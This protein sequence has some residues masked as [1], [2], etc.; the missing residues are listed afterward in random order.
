M[1]EK[2]AKPTLEVTACELLGRGE[3][4]DI[5][6]D[7]DSFLKENNL[8]ASTTSVSYK[9][10]V[11]IYKGKRICRLKLMKENYWIF[12]LLIYKSFTD[13]PEYMSYVND[14]QKEFLLAHF[15]PRTPCKNCKGSGKIEFLGNEYETYCGCYPIYTN[16]DN[17]RESPGLP[18]RFKELA[19][20]SKN[21]LDGIATA[22]K[23]GKSK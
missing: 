12:S 9:V 14:E 22:K 2:T 5:L 1:P 23:I 8:K 19:L 7:L 4:L 10:W 21:I 16:S 20:V 6:L 11:V 15:R 18:E 13:T 3:A 17:L